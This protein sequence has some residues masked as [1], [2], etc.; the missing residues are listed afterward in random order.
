MRPLPLPEQLACR[1]SPHRGLAS[2]RPGRPCCSASSHTGLHAGLHAIG[3]TSF[4]LGISFSSFL[5][6]LRSTPALPSRPLSVGA[7]PSASPCPLSSRTRP[8]PSQ[9]LGLRPGCSR[10]RARF[11]PNAPG[12]AGGDRPLCLQR[13]AHRTHECE[14]WRHPYS[15]GLGPE[16][17]G[18][19]GVV[20]F[21]LLHY[22]HKHREALGEGP[23]LTRGACAS[24]SPLRPEGLKVTPRGVFRAPAFRL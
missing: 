10:L 4:L 15:K 6:P 23:G 9:P 13:H 19:S 18:N 16:G 22:L 1:S 7:N 5:W 17:F 3:P 20:F 8:F 11:P 21:V 2:Q 24:R 12:T 14:R